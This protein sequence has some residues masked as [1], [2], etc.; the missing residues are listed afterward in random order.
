MRISPLLLVLAVLASL[1]SAVLAQRSIRPARTMQP[2][3]SQAEL[4][5]FFAELARAVPRS[6]RERRDGQLSDNAA[7]APMSKDEESITNL[8][9]AGVDEGGIVKLHGEHLVVLRR[10][11]L[12][13]VSL[14]DASLRPV[15]TIDAYA[16][17]AEP[18]DW[19]DEMLISGDRVIVIGYSYRR[20]GTE[21]GV[22][23]IDGAGTLRHVTTSHLRSN[24]YYS[25]R[26]Y[27]SRLVG[28]KL[29][30]YTPLMLWLGGDPLAALPAIREWRPGADS[31]QFERIVTP[32]RVYRPARSLAGSHHL[33]LHTIT[34]C[35]VGG[36]RLECEANV[37]VGPWSRVFYVS[38]KSVYVWAADWPWN[39]PDG[40]RAQAMLYRLPLDG[41]P[42]SGLAVSGSPVDQFSFLES[43]DGHLNVVVRADAA[44]DAMWSAERTAGDV[45]LLRMPTARF[46]DGSGAAPAKWYRELPTAPPGVFQNRFVGEY[47]LYGAGNG[48]WKPT[49][50]DASLFVVPWKGGGVSQVGLPHGV[51]RIEVMG[52]DAV[53]VG[54]GNGRLHFSGIRLGDRPVVVQRFALDN[55]SQGELRSHGFFYRPDGAGSGTLGLPVRGGVRPGW[56]H[57]IHGSASI[58]FLRNQGRQFTRLGDLAS[59]PEPP[60]DDACKASCVDWYGNA[61]PIFAKGRIFA[62]LGYE[63]VEGA[64]ENGV[65]RELG[66]TSFAPAPVRTTLR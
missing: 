38:P 21:V 11:R 19:Y 65:M 49:T 35:D 10:G 8:Q 31:T 2:F 26:N 33:T 52:P 60:R 5:Q 15:S 43:D 50:N 7:A 30:F 14:A 6:A 16:P 28:G 12:F 57:L 25:S 56:E 58:V 22:F 39:R 29:V 42:P 51:D 18:A 34:Q 9:H 41:S 1:P 66:R 64:V 55:V 54:A 24:D 3:R 27:A 59:R 17:G 20:G 63:L 46:D 48:W 45:A 44:G 53:I 61:R 62:L 47:L 36:P 37:V 13:T 4:L 40:A 23:Q 32:R